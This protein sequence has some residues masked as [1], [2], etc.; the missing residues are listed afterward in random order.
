MYTTCVIW[1]AFV[2]L[3]F[4][5]ASHVPLRVTSM[6][7]TISL[8]ASVTLVCLFSPKVSHNPTRWE[9]LA[10]HRQLHSSISRVTAVYYRVSAGTQRAREPHAGQVERGGRC[11]GTGETWCG[12][13]CR[14][15]RVSGRRTRTSTTCPRG[16]PHT[17]HR[18]L[19]AQRHRYVT[20]TIPFIYNVPILTYTSYL[21]CMLQSAQRHRTG[22]CRRRKRH[23]TH[24]L[25]P[26]VKTGCT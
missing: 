3:Y 22:K 5:T 23:C 19:H 21:T 11:R 8:S 15:R 6:A 7:V 9:L 10:G 24:G 25:R 12:R 1:L 2:P 4:G 18:P 16:R 13:R 26:R 20:Q 14:V 17:I